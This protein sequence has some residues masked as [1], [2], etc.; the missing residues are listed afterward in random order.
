S[1]CTMEQ[2]QSLVHQTSLN[3]HTSTNTVS[4]L[5]EKYDHVMDSVNRNCAAVKKLDNDLREA[6]RDNEALRQY[7]YRENIEVSGIPMVS[8]ENFNQNFLKI[9]TALGVHMSPA[10]IFTAHR[11]KSRR[12]D[13]DQPPK[14][15]AI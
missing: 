13:N 3:I 2:I 5:A 11:V 8:N 7:S 4:F 1:Q 10:D 14:S 6:K 12:T 9:A 15:I